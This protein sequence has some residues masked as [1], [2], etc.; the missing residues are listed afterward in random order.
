M[1]LI[2][3]R[4]STCRRDR[5]LPAKFSQCWVVLVT[6]GAVMGTSSTVEAQ[7][8]VPDCRQ[9]YVCHQ[10]SC[11][12]ACNPLCPEAERC[13]SDGQ[14]VAATAPSPQPAAAATATLP[15]G[16]YVA[17]RDRALVV[18]VRESGSRQDHLTIIDEQSR[19]L[20]LIEKP[21]RHLKSIV[22]PGKHTFY[23]GDVVRADVA[24]G[25]TYVI[26][27]TAKRDWMSGQ[28]PSVAEP[29][30]RNSK[31]FSASPNW[32]RNTKLEMP[33]LEKH[34]MRWERDFNA[35]QFRSS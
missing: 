5:H 3:M 33:D 24:A 6:M 35:R 20:T 2:K 25:R 17:P 13:T 31:A 29:A 14:C 4:A 7:S 18:F 8:C 16:S 1:N 34:S 32:I 15:A 11:V 22:T 28:W 19:F 30:L 12:S 10:G 21:G 26:R 23:F 27:I 9:G